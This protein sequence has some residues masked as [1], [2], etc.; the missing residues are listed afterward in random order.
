M[1]TLDQTFY[2]TSVSNSSHSLPER[3]WTFSW[4]ITNSTKLLFIIFITPV[5]SI[6][7]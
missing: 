4:V 1:I 7:W 5:V 6:T 3:K 2:N